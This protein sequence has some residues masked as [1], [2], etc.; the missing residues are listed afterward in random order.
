MKRHCVRY[1]SVH[2]NERLR[3]NKENQKKYQAYLKAKSKHDKLVEKAAALLEKCKQVEA[4][5]FKAQDRLAKQWQPKID[6][7]N[8]AEAKAGKVALDLHLQL[9]ETRKSFMSKDNPD[10]KE[11]F[12]LLLD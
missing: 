10:H 9:K 2:L 8:K 12:N 5:Y 11:L 7:V 6:K 4:D 3:M 1:G